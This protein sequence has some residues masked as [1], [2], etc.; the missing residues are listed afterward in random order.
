MTKKTSNKK[1]AEKIVDRFLASN[2]VKQVVLLAKVLWRLATIAVP[3]YVGVHLL[4]EF[5]DKI[6]VGIGVAALLFATLRVINSAYLAEVKT[7]KQS[8]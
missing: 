3:A 6:V 1:Q 4:R 8:Q 7:S 2:F 5:D